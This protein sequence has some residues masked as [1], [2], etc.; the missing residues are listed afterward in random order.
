MVAT[1]AFRHDPVKAVLDLKPGTGAP[2]WERE[3]AVCGYRR[4]YHDSSS[5]GRAI[6]VPV[7]ASPAVVTGVG[8]VAASFDGWVRL[9]DR[10][11]TTVYWE[12]RLD[13]PV[14]SSLVVDQ[15]RRTV[16]V[17][18]TSGRVACFDLRGQ[19]VWHTDTGVQLYATPTVLPESGVLVLAGFGSR[20]LG[21]ELATGRQLFD[22]E[23]PR[24]WHAAIGGSAAHRDPYASPVATAEGNVVLGCAEHVLCLAADGS[25]LWR[26][27]LG[28]AVR[29]SPAALH[30]VGEVAV[31]S[32]DGICHFMDA[33]TGADRGQVGLGAKIVASPAVSGDILIVGTCDDEVVGIDVRRHQPAWRATGSPRDHTSFSVL[34]SGDFMAT[35]TSGNAVG[36]GRDDGRFLWQTSQLLGLGEH[37]PAMDV[38]PVAGSDGSMY[39]ASYTGVLYHFRFRPGLDE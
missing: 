39:C 12:R 33:R 10:D 28:S 18:A 20:C 2:Q 7:S 13:S 3:P 27:E 34:P 32:V 14:Y 24:P 31:C 35:T 30:A 17:A 29:A 1:P 25:Q 38:T 8:A 15:E 37:D 26:R 16:L 22:R 5:A 4:L 9:F 21:L 11:L 36:R 19:T 23:L 6:P